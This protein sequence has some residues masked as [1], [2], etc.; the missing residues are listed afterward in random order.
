MN[1]WNLGR[2]GWLCNLK[3][4][5]ERLLFPDTRVDPKVIL[6]DLASW[7]DVNYLAVCRVPGEKAGTPSTLGANSEL[8]VILNRESAL[9]ASV[10]S[11]ELEILWVGVISTQRIDLWNQ[12]WDSVDQI[13][14]WETKDSII[15]WQKQ[16]KTD[17]G[18]YSSSP[19]VWPSCFC[20][21]NHLYC[22]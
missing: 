11:N 3:S 12:Q 2:M 6:N 17:M 21:L 9:Q 4:W 15:Q 19:T 8:R 16:A 22:L 18:S 14:I 5:V 1:S 13:Y 10:F 20:F 7:E